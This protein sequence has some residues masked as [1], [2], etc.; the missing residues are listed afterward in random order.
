MI[1]TIDVD[2]FRKELTQRLTELLLA[3]NG[4]GLELDGL[5][6]TIKAIDR[7]IAEINKA[8]EATYDPTAYFDID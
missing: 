2:T 6:A 4:Y 1:E 5:K 8:F 3:R 7:E